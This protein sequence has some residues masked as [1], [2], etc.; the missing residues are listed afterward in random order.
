MSYR[1]LVVLPTTQASDTNPVLKTLLAIILLFR[2]E[3]ADPCGGPE[4]DR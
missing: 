4:E 2:E 3:R 1:D